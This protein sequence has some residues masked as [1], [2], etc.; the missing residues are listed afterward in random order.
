[1]ATCYR[2]G[3]PNATYRREVYIGHSN[4]IYFGRRISSSRSSSYGIRSVCQNCATE[5]DK[6]SSTMTIIIVCVV[7][8]IILYLISK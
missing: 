5:I 4:R 6:Q 3:A 1:M 8:V 2:C 7:I